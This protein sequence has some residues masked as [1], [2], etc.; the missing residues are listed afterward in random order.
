MCRS[1]LNPAVS[2]L[3]VIYLTNENSFCFGSLSYFFVFCRG[4]MS[5]L[6]TAV[7]LASGCV[8]VN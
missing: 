8:D 7:S 5:I 2:P 1:V 6:E 4:E 3:T